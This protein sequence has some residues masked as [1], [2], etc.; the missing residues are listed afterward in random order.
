[1]INCFCG[2]AI[3]KI[4]SKCKTSIMFSL[5]NMEIGTFISFVE[6]LG[7]HSRSK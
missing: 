6:A 3:D 5:L 1:M 7:A 2:L 4:S